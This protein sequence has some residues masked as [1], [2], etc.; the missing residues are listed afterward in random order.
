MPTPSP[1]RAVSFDLDG[2]LYATGHHRLRL[3]PRLL[4]QLG[5]IRAW[6][7]AVAAQRGR[8]HGD[9]PERI[10]ADT[11]ARLGV[12]T[13][14]ARARL[15][16]FLDRTWIPA[17]RPRHVLPGLHDAIAVLDGRGIPRAVASDHPTAAKLA[18]LG[19]TGGWTARLDGESLGALK[20]SPRVL[21][22]AAGAM[23]VPPGALLHIGD[24]LDTDA[25]AAQAAGAR[26]L[27]VLDERGSS[28]SLARRIVALLD[29]PPAVEAP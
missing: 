10:V 1:I 2:T 23:D 12:S 22:E 11:A 18:G 21:L 17:L 25:L 3:A 26:Y 29:H 4:P 27:H 15:W 14:E 19:L 9:L 13:D 28:A 7:A 16:F 8:E 5:L 24:R 20:P 6:S